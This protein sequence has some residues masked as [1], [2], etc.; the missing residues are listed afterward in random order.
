MHYRVHQNREP[1]NRCTAEYTKIKNS[2]D[3]ETNPREKEE[4]RLKELKN[5]QV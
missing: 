1:K 5:N 4:K 3:I 2:E